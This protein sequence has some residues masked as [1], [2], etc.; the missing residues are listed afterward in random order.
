MNEIIKVNY[1][2]EQPTVSARDLKHIYVLLSKNKNVK[3][4]VSKNIIKRISAIEGASGYKIVDY[5]ITEK[6]SNSYEIEHMAHQYFRDNRLFGEWFKVDFN[7][8]VSVVKEL[9]AKHSKI[10]QRNIE[11]DGIS[12]LLQM[13]YPD[14]AFCGKCEF[15]DEFI[16]LAISLGEKMKE[17][18]M[19]K[20]E[21]GRLKNARISH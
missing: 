11:K 21:N 4:G 20:E 18:K 8:A 5:F 14:N 3:I 17:L 16:D 6:C 1:D 15:S 13:L 9:Y 10:L 12:K 19:L 2:G 7:N